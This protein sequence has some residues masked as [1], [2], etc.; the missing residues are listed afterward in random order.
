MSKLPTKLSVLLV[1]ARIIIAATMTTLE[2]IGRFNSATAQVHDP[3]FGPNC[4]G[5]ITTKNLADSAVTNPKLADGAIT[6]KL[7]PGAVSISITE[8]R[9][10][11]IVPPGSIRG[12]IAICP[13]GSVVT[14]GGYSVNPNGK[15][16]ANDLRGGDAEWSVEAP[17]EES[18]DETTTAI[19]FC[20]PINP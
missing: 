2:A 1:A 16:F 7:A 13:L 15:V 4:N 18:H 10:S 9:V 5:C 17:N 8:A 12:Q 14:G 19:A 11:A 20:A 6:G 3:P